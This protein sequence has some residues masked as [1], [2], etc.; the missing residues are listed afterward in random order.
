MTSKPPFSYGCDV[1]GDLLVSGS[2]RDTTM[3]VWAPGLSKSVPLRRVGGGGISHVAWSPDS[4]K[5]FAATTNTV[6][7]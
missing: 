5:V 1:Q 2:A 3:Y 6:F 7:R 4:L